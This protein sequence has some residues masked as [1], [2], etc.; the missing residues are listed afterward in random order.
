MVEFKARN[1]EIEAVRSLVENANK[2]LKDWTVL[3]GVYRYDRHDLAFFTACLT[4]VCGLL[5]L[6]ITHGAPIWKD[7][8]GLRPGVAMK[9][10]ARKRRKKQEEKEEVQEDEEEEVEEEEDDEEEE[11][12]YFE[13]DRITGHYDSSDH[14]RM[15]RVRY[16]GCHHSKD[17]WLTPELITGDAVEHYLA[18][19][20]KSD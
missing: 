8:T 20:A 17:L 12:E 11:E 3:Y 5:N 19:L 16:K 13:I 14:G 6:Q 1:E 9:R 18:Q 2:R 4:S 7:L 15:Y 10:Q